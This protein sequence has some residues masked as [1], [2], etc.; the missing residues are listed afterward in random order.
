[1]RNTRIADK[2]SRS[3]CYHSVWSTITVEIC[4]LCFYHVLYYSVYS[5]DRHF[6]LYLLV[7]LLYYIY[8]QL[9][10]FQSP[11]RLMVG[12]KHGE[13]LSNRNG[14]NLKPV[15]LRSGVTP[16]VVVIV[17]QSRVHR[18]KGKPPRVASSN[19]QQR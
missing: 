5:T 3:I 13:L 18:V 17:V 1:M 8:L 12:I 11:L 10:D 16:E 15:P 6:T 4:T 14:L 19:A 2:V 9:H 7:N